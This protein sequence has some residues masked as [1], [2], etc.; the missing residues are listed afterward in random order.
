MGY[1][2][3]AVFEYSLEKL[4]QIY[5]NTFTNISKRY[6]NDIKLL[7]SVFSITNKPLNVVQLCFLFSGEIM[8]PDFRY[9][10]LLMDI[11]GFLAIYRE[12]KVNTYMIGNAAW[13][14]GL[15]D[16]Y[17]DECRSEVISNVWANISSMLNDSLVW[18]CS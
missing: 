13:K 12:N 2:N 6:H 5:V 1:R 18:S 3:R 14:K 17:F 9:Y 7:L 15:A 16:A 10:F 4:P 8:M 11:S